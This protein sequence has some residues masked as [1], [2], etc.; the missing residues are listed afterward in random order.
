MHRSKILADLYNTSQSKWACCVT[1]CRYMTPKQ[2]QKHLS[3]LRKGLIQSNKKRPQSASPARTT[4]SSLLT[5]TPPHTARSSAQGHGAWD[6]YTS[7]GSSVLGYNDVGAYDMY[8]PLT[9]SPA[10]SLQSGLSA[11]GGGGGVPPYA[12]AAGQY[13]RET[14]DRYGYDL[15]AGVPPLP[16]HARPQ[17]PALS[18]RTSSK[19]PPRQYQHHPAHQQYPV[20]SP[21]GY[22]TSPPPPYGPASDGR[23]YSSPDAR[24]HDSVYYGASP[25][26][27]PPGMPPMQPGMY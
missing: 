5:D 27:T 23:F 8:S 22:Y 1:H 3:K 18:S 17:S 6:R 7:P 2:M 19:S 13:G 4:S 9:L 14:A 20:H 24:F 21:R 25:H 10:T 16:L 26:P 12:G 15:H 11:V